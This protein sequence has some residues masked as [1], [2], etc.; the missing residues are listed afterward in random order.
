MKEGCCRI[1]DVLALLSLGRRMVLN[2]FQVVG[3]Y[4]YIIVESRLL[5]GAISPS[6]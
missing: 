4:S 1:S 2:Q 3:S 5:K 6:K